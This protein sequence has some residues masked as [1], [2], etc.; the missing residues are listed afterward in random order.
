MLPL[1]LLVTSVCVYKIFRIEGGSGQSSHSRTFYTL[2]EDIKGDAGEC[3]A[4]C[5]VPGQGVTK[6]VAGVEVWW[7]VQRE[8]EIAREQD[9]SATHIVM[10]TISG[11]VGGYYYMYFEV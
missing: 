2:Q 1:L 6:G 10:R 9:S 8:S 3:G 11:N 4:V 5:M 7:P